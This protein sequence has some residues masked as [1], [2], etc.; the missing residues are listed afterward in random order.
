[1]PAILLQSAHGS[2]FGGA[3][4]PFSVFQVLPFFL[5]NIPVTAPA[6]KQNR[7]LRAEGDVEQCIALKII[8]LSLSIC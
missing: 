2:F 4:A 6:Y 3:F 8:D 1:M 7:F 5:L